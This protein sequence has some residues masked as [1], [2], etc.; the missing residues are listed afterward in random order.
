MKKISL[1]NVRIDGGTQSRLAIDQ[2]VV[3]HYV[4][5]M[6]EGDEFPA[7]DTVFDGSVYWLV[8]GFHR[9]HAYK[10]LGIKQIDV[11]YKPGT[12]LE[13]QVMSFGVNGRH[14]KPRSIEDKRNA[15]EQALVHELTKDKSNYELAK[16]CVVSQSFVASVRDP[17][18]KKKQAENIKK[19]IQKKAKEITSQQDE[20]T[21]QT[22]SPDH[23]A[24]VNDAAPDEAELRANELA[25]Q[26]DIEMMNKILES[27]DVLVTLKDEVTR[28][29]HENVQLEVRLHGLMN[30][31]NEAV[32][33]VKKLQKELDKLK[34]KK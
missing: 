13:A 9:Y 34:A 31:R 11:I 17:E 28:L 23:V 7:L 8:D 27:D 24:P 22:S 30:E 32:K 15:V 16:I 18:V 5:C 12:Q 3:Y 25:M 20:T 26:A 19:H 33:M 14:G 21:S 2:S 4:E 29:T 6:K 1:S 10:L